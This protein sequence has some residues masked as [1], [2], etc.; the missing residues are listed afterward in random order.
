MGRMLKA[1]AVVAPRM[2]LSIMRS[3]LAVS[4]LERD[5]RRYEA[6][7]RGRRTAGW[8]SSNGSANSE[9]SYAAAILRA[10]ARDLER[11][12]PWAAKGIATI[13]AN[14]IG[15]GIRARVRHRSKAKA[16]RATEAWQ[17]W[18]DSTACDFDGRHDLA[19]L[20]ALVLQT[21]VR[22]GEALC[23]FRRVPGMAIPLQLQ[24][25]E[26]DHLDPT[27][28]RADSPSMNR[29]IEGVEID[30]EGRIVA[31]WLYPQHPGDAQAGW[32][33]LA[34]PK[35]ISKRIPAADVLRVYRQDRAGQLRGASWLAPVMLGLRD[36]DDYEDA[37]LMRQKVAACFSV[38][39][40]D[41]AE[42][43]PGSGL[44]TDP[45]D[46]PEQVQPGMIEHL[47]PGKSVSFASPPGVD[48]YVDYVR[49]LLRRAAAGLGIT[50]EALTGDL[51]QT[52]FSGGRLG[53]IEMGRHI[54]AWRW[55]MF[56]PQFC[57]PIFARFVE[58]AV[59]A[60]QDIA[61]V[62]ADWTAPRRELISPK[63]EILAEQ[64]AVRSGFKSWSQSVRESGEDPEV[65]AEEIAADF[66][67]FDRLGLVLDCD[68][69][70][71]TFQG[72]AQADPSPSADAETKPQ[73]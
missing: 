16:K 68:P 8:H 28:Q 15:A 44:P 62:E 48:G 70:K 27:R 66:K 46:L 25:L 50:Y 64:M 3:R 38:F 40:H 63:D 56:V 47:P 24:V 7:A 30:D 65:V 4:M 71:T 21:T 12:N 1:L 73:E 18:A 36:L 35:L 41:P 20:Q 33:L 54:E 5:V 37:Q 43:L 51:T 17:R 53:W 59:L 39:V 49:M 9:T 6:A 55:R 67:R 13:T 45:K 23:V 69:R 32:T 61:G 60:G 10:R 34:Q 26:P 58:A 42:G 52:S 2:A 72:Q 11:N 29:I 19:G 14:V 22:D 31:Y 57:V